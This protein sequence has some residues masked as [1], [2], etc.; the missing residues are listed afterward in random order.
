MRW[1]M[2]EGGCWVLVNNPYQK[3]IDYLRSED[4]KRHEKLSL[5]PMSE[6]HDIRIGKHPIFKAYLGLQ[7]PNTAVNRE[8]AALMFEELFDDF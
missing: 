7:F 1:K 3:G 8:L 6:E 4:C 5:K 2:T